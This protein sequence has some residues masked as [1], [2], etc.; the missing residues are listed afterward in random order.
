MLSTKNFF[1]SLA[2]LA[3]CPPGANAQGWPENYGG[4]M[5]QGFYWDSFSQ[6]KWTKLEAQADDLAAT[7]SLVWVPQSGKCLETHNVMGY[8]PYYYFNQNS[9][10]GSEEEL[11]S[12][13]RTF[14]DK[15]IGTI[16]DVVINHH[17]TNG[18][19]TFPAETYN[20]ATYQ[21]Q[22]TDIVSNDDYD[23]ATGKY[24]TREQAAIDGV[25]L[26]SNN[27]EGED[28]GGMRDLDHKSEN[29]QRIMKAYVKFLKDEIGRAHV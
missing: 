16:A 25:T 14:R 22:T 28:W 26:S 3:A 17:N 27:D 20:G 29:V 9:S 1:L 24:K 5:L 15:G 7:F 2:L 21:L 8:T 11:R 23:P 6:S 13:I 12:M 19:W 10:F 4:V 18:W